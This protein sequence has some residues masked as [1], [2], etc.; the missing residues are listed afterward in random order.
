MT[1]QSLPP[2]PQFT[3]EGSL[4]GYESFD[5]WH[6]EFEERSLVA[7]WSKEKKKYRLKMHLHNTAYHMFSEE[8]KSSYSALVKAL[9]KRFQPVDIEELR[10]MEFHQITQESESVKEIG[11]KLQVLAREAFPIWLGKN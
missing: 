11:I 3:G 2:L 7:R 4:V 10:G 9:R 5:H 1:A 6:E 8:T